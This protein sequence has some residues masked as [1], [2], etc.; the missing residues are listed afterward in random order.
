MP[1]SDLDKRRLSKYYSVLSTLWFDERKQ[2]INLQSAQTVLNLS[3]PPTSI[4]IQHLVQERILKNQLY[5][6]I[7]EKNAMKFELVRTQEN[8]ENQFDPNYTHFKN[9]AGKLQNFPVIQEF[10][11]LRVMTYN[12]WF[13]AHNQDNRLEA[14]IQMILKSNANV[15]CLQECTQTMITKLSQ[16][17][18]ITTRYKYWGKQ[19]FK[20]FYGCIILSWWPPSSI[21]EYQYQATSRHDTEVDE[22]YLNAGLSA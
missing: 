11:N 17:K 7:E 9:F 13:D 6:L 21:Y 5:R 14:I 8:Y 3:T 2:E 15:V 16:N 22:N 4:V 1:K 10:V 20:S 12:V 19:E 18:Q